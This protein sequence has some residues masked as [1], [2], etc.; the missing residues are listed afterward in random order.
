MEESEMD[1]S[2]SMGFG[3]LLSK[4]DFKWTEEY[5]MV[6]NAK[7]A[8]TD[9]ENNLNKNE[10]FLESC[11]KDRSALLAVSILVE[12]GERKF[13]EMA[14]QAQKEVLKKQRAIIKA[15]SM[16]EKAHRELAKQLR[17]L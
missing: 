2:Y 16:I 4:I 10:R 5:Q 15:T 13:E 7:R 8:V 12:Y 14:E 17:A 9:A 1:Q 11:E 3:A 6:E